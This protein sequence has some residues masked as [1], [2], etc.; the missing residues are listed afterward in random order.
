MS[1]LWRDF[2]EEIRE[3]EQE[4]DAMRFALESILVNVDSLGSGKIPGV[5]EPA[6]WYFRNV[7]AMCRDALERRAAQAAEGRGGDAHD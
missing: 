3:V 4:R 5:G 1:Y 7:A 2:D 6:A